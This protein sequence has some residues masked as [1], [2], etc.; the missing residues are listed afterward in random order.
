MFNYTSVPAFILRFAMF[1]LLF[2]TYP[3]VHYFLNS[4]L[5]QIFWQ[6]S[7]I[8]RKSELLLNVGLTFIPLLFALFYPNIGTV[9]SFAGALPGFLII[10]LLPVM[11]HLKRMKT[12]IENPL[13]AEAID[14]NAFG[15]SIGKSNGGVPST[16]KIT[17]N[18]ELPRKR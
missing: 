8:T 15:S 12:R 2:S 13:L 9:L 5:L 6:N 16:P 18:D 17:V 14:L 3:L 1:A 4:M 7:Q 11:V 10:Y